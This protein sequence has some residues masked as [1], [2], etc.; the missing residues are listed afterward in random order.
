MTTTPDP[1]AVDD[2]DLAALTQRLAKAA[3][4]SGDLDVAYRHLDSPVGQLLLAATDR[5][6]VRVAFAAEGFDA[7]LTR[8]A[9]AIS[10]RILAAPRRLDHAAREV[11]EYFDGTR[12]T[13][14]LALD[15]SLS[16]GF[17]QQVQRFLPQIAYGSTVSYK[18][19]AERVGNPNAV[20]AVG[21]ACATNPLP[22]VV[23]CHRVLRSDGSPGGY[24]GG[25]EA[26]A[27]LLRLEREGIGE[28]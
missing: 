17:R 25:L 16:T 3:D 27:V 23:P 24:V 19:I 9:D 12:R 20:R 21:S 10:P 2:S 8:I 26:K 18:D 22:I 11:D 15:D 4:D 5:G 14:D 13:F 6:L 1:F 7:V 28:R